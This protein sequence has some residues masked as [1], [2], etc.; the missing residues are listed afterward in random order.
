MSKAKFEEAKALIQAKRYDEARAILETIDHPTAKAW[1]SKIEGLSSPKSTTSKRTSYLPIVAVS[2]I[3]AFLIGLLAGALLFRQPAQQSQSAAALITL[4]PTNPPPTAI[5]NTLPP[6]WTATPAATSTPV[7]TATPACSVRDWWSNDAE[8]LVVKFLDTAETAGQTARMSLSSVILDMRS[9]FREF[10]K[11]NHGPC[12][13]K[14][15][16][17]LRSGMSY[18]IDGFNE[19]LGKNEIVSAVDFDLATQSLWNAYTLLF[20]QK[21]IPDVR[22][23]NASVFIWSGT[24]ATPNAMTATAQFNKYGD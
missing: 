11:L 6:T 12:T 9:T 10:D 21:A 14:I 8:P 19:F 22:M 15:Y 3:P 7:A 16:R 5:V 24:G 1:L 18:A 20:E 23:S 2:A 13:D 4:A 17:Q